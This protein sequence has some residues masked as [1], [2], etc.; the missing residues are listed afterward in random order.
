M[1]ESCD[2]IIRNVPESVS[3]F[4]LY[5][6]IQPALLLHGDGVN[7]ST[8]LVDSMGRHAVTAEGLCW[9]D[10]TQSVFGGASILF[11]DS[12]A[13]ANVNNLT[14]FNFGLDDFT[15]DCWVRPSALTG[16]IFFNGYDLDLYIF[17]DGSVHFADNVTARIVTPAGALAINRWD[18]VALIRASGFTKMY[19]D[20]TQAGSTF[21][22]SNNY[23]H[24]NQ[25]RVGGGYHGNT[26]EFRVIKGRAAWMSDFTP[27]TSAY[28]P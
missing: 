13:Y 12:L 27:P 25:W 20:G 28:L 16:D 8:V 3:S 2:F 19:I 18:H 22:D 7:L 4:V 5:A 15:I 9:I 17:P 14:D 6:D 1:D 21:V 26:D 11:E 24:S 23:V 10:T